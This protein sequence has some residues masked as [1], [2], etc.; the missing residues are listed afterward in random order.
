[1]LFYFAMIGCEGDCGLPWDEDA[2]A[3]RE[4]LLDPIS[5]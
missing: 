1:M 2:I 3:R 4:L 5:L